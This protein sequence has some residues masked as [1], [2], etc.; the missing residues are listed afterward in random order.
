MIVS[1]SIPVNSGA[2][3]PFCF[4]EGHAAEVRPGFAKR[5]MQVKIRSLSRLMSI[6]LTVLF[7]SNIGS[8]TC[9]SVGATQQLHQVYPVSRASIAPTN[10]ARVSFALDGDLLRARFEV[11]SKEIYGNRHLGSRQYPYQ[12]DVVEVFVSVTGLDGAHVP[13]YEFELSPYDQDFQVKIPGGKKPFVNGVQMGLQHE[14]QRTSDGWVAT[15]SI[16]L[17]NLE[18]DGHP[19]KII[20]NAF[21]V[22]GARPNRIYY[23]LNLPEQARPNFHLPEFFKPLLVCGA[24]GN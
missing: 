18:W 10:P 21:V 5:W 16:P 17:R 20:G 24:E 11:K 12:W 6:S 14:V 15:L 1:P 9:T 13:Y 23:S 7:V 3:R 8:A 4:V 22:L 19:E 2:W